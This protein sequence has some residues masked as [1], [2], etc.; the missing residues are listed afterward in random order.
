MLKAAYGLAL[1][2]AVA[3]VVLWLT[4]DSPVF[5][6]FAVLGL[7]TAVAGWLAGRSAGDRP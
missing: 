6:V 4:L 1:L 7:V 5:L 3:G 2:V